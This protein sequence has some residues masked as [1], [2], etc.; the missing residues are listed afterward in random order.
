MAVREPRGYTNV[1]TSRPSSWVTCFTLENERL[2][3]HRRI[4]S[5]CSTV[6]YI[7]SFTSC[8]ASIRASI[9]S[10]TTNRTKWVF[11]FCPILVENFS[12]WLLTQRPCCSGAYRKTRPNACISTLLFHQGSTMMTRL[13]WV[14]L[15]ACPPHLSPIIRILIDDFRWKASKASFRAVS[16]MLPVNCMV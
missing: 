15:R 2:A 14:M 6:T 3:H 5:Q 8:V 10:R 7:F 11:F 16:P 13:A 9:E 1:R 12:H 4:K